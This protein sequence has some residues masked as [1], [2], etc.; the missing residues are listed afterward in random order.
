MSVYETRLIVL[1]WNLLKV[2]AK[3]FGK[4]TYKKRHKDKTKRW[5]SCITKFSLYFK[6]IFETK[7]KYIIKKLTFIGRKNPGNHLKS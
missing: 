3:V 6:I 4:L 7:K 2:N 5:Y 1:S